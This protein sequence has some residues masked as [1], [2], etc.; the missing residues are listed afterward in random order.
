[1]SG[2]DDLSTLPVNNK[3]VLSPQEQQ[4]IDLYFPKDES[5]SCD[6]LKVVGYGALL[7]MVLANPLS[8][9]LLEKIPFCNGNQL[10][11]MVVKVL[12]FV[13]ALFL[14]SR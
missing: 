12:I 5:G 11:L 1:M 4:V 13:V 3:T 14:L 2:M 7:F 8:E 10:C 9:G 6:N